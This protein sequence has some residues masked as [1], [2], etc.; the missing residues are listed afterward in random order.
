MDKIGKCWD[1]VDGSVGKYKALVT[2]REQRKKRAYLEKIRNTPL[3]IFRVKNKSFI[4]P[5]ESR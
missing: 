2:P 5:K 3:V 4:S 1:E